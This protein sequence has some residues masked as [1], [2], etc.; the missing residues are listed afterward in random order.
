MMGKRTRPGIPPSRA[1]RERVWP[2]TAFT[3]TFWEMSASNRWQLAAAA[4]GVNSP[5]LSIL[6]RREIAAWLER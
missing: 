2:G 4:Q 3:R 1:F 5:S 6:R